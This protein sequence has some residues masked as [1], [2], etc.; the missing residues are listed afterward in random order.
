MKPKKSFFGIFLII[1]LLAAL[2][3]G[4]YFL[5][6]KDAPETTDDT[7]GGVN[8]I[9]DSGDTDTEGDVE[10][11]PPA[12][13]PEPEPEPEEEPEAT[14][15]DFTTFSATQQTVGASANTGTYTLKS[16]VDSKQDGFHRFI[17]TVQAKTS[18]IMEVPYTVVAYKS[19]QGVIR[20]DL[21]GITT[22][23]SGI[24]Y[25]KS[26]AI[27]EQGISKLYHNISADPK[28][29]LYDIGVTKST[30][31]KV[32]STETVNNT[33]TITVDVKYPGGTVS[34]GVYG[35]ETFSKDLQAL[36]GALVPDNAKI[37]SYS[38]STSG[39]V[40][41]LVFNVSGSA[42]RPVPSATGQYESGL[43]TLTFPG[44][45][46]DSAY[47]ALDGKVFANGITIQTSR[48]GA[49]ST[50]EFHGTSKDFRLSGGTSPNQV[51]M[52]IKL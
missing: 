39:G 42:S 41:S 30:P 9:D 3:V 19:A 4:A 43:L 15:T 29:E 13:E 34:T 7:G 22:D 24:A 40:F 5:F 8:I 27:N 16:I 51:I 10:E 20:V 25:Q 28:E 52:E 12:A 47:K 49:E 23:Q 17:F 46:L 36:D 32:V 6:K 31:F 1:L 14:G 37:I 48:S 45:T 38:Y 11:T 26:R 50:Y 33:W 18:D 21:N 2:G 35:S 44:L